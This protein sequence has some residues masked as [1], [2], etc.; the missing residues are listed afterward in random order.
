MA[1]EERM[2]KEEWIQRIEVE[3]RDQ[4]IREEMIRLGF[5]ENKP[6]SPEEKEQIERE[7]AE[8][9]Q[10]QSELKRLRR[11]SHQLGNID[12]LLKQARA[13]RIKESQRRR[14]KQK[15][16]RARKIKD[17]KQRWKEYT[18]T[19]IVHAGVGVSAGL[20]SV[21]FEEE[22][23]IQQNLPLL[24][25]SLELATELGISLSKLKWLTFHRG[26]ATLCHYTQFTIPKK[27]WR[28]ARNLCSQT[29]FTKSTT[30]D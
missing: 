13:K 9:K 18:T 2:T 6:L 23:L 19:H 30:V 3:G 5:W 29:G 12:Q 11:E 15:K 10:L 14:E 27:K 28:K 25:S 16:E 20:D 8:L 4:V 24:R 22:K 1:E 7:K 17:A 21:K 26:T